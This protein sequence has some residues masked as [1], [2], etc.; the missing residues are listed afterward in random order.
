MGR[1]TG[2][3][4]RRAPPNKKAGIDERNSKRK[5]AQESE[6]ILRK[7]K[8]KRKALERNS[9]NGARRVDVSRALVRF[10]VDARLL[11]VHSD[12][13][14][15]RVDAYSSNVRD[16]GGLRLARDRLDLARKPLST[17]EIGVPSASLDGVASTLGD[18][19]GRRGDLERER[20]R[21]CLRKGFR[22]GG[23]CVLRRRR[24]GAFRSTLGRDRRERLAAR[25]GKRRG[26][27]DEKYFGRRSCN[28]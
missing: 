17:P 22:N 25:V 12:G 21:F 26:V 7:R 28:V 14:R 5:A 4:R 3:L 20:R 27:V 23:L 6:R 19:G 10:R 16:S 18:G 8:T 9:F 24:G 2:N 13:A 1:L 15:R 11:R